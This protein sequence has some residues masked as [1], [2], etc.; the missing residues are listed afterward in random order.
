MENLAIQSASKIVVLGLAIGFGMIIPAQTNAQNY[1]RVTEASMA[2][3][4]RNNNSN[5]GNT[6]N[7]TLNGQEAVPYAYGY[8]FNMP[9]DSKW[10]YIAERCYSS[11]DGNVCVSGHWIRR[12]PG[13]CEETSS[14]SIR[15]GNYIRIVPAGP[16]SSCRN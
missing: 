2:P 12:V 16:V 5:S 1:Q 14:H 3:A 4:P 7:Y 11:N 9:S 6:S 10:R 13:R 8:S 15:R